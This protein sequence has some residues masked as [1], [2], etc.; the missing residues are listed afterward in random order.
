VRLPDAPS[1]PTTTARRSPSASARATSRSSRRPPR[2]WPRLG[3]GVDPARHVAVGGAAEI[4]AR[5]GE[6]R[7]VGASKFVLLPIAGGDSDVLAQTERLIAE[8]LP[9]AHRS[10]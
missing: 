6:F 4:L 3:D 10:R 7:D 5:I 1:T 8:V 2:D 9:A